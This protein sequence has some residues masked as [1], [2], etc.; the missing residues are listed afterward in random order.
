MWEL[1]RSG[2]IMMIPLGLCSLIAVA[3]VLERFFALRY[4]KVIL[5][6]VVG[7][8]ET[9]GASTDFSVAQAILER[10]RGPFANIVTAGLAHSEDDWQIVRDALQEAGR[11]ESVQVNR[12]LNILEAIAGV[13]PL[14]GLLGTVTGMIRVFASISAQGLGNPEHLSGGISEAMIT[15]AAGLII[16]IPT[17][18]A[19]YWLQGR[20]DHIVFG[21]E[22]YASRVLDTLR[23]RR[24]RDGKRTGQDPR[25]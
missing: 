24:G 12:H 20:A 16:G 25:S 15:T 19:H 14:L 18:A 4:N 6:E 2:N 13:A 17:L 7:A 22:Q 23:S 9:L 10:N 5:P 21:L 1:I 3:V 8:V 11:Q